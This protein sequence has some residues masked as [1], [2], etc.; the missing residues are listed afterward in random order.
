MNFN[1]PYQATPHYPLDTKDLDVGIAQ[2]FYQVQDGQHRIIQPD[3]AASPME[4]H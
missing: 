4:F 3:D 1:N 2:L